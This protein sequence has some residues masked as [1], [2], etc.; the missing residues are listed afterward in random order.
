MALNRIVCNIYNILMTFMA[1]EFFVEINLNRHDA[2]ECVKCLSSR[3]LCTSGVLT[4]IFWTLSRDEFVHVLQF[5]DICVS[6]K[7]AEAQRS[8]IFHFF[9]LNPT[10]KQYDVRL[11][12]KS[13][14]HRTISLTF[15]V[16]NTH[17]YAKYCIMYYVDTRAICFVYFSV[18]SV[19][20]QNVKL[21]SIKII[22]HLFIN[23]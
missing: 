15:Y 9:I 18:I 8:R 7:T 20:R 14:R 22:L 23:Q 4:F 2:V 19:L 13:L 21:C 11:C 17:S 12:L 3:T 1:P 6:T 5:V 16:I 10:Y